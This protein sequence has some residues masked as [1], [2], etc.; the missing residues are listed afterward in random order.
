MGTLV[1]VVL[2]AAL[3]VWPR[4]GHPPHADAVVVLSGDHGERLPAALGLMKR[5][6]APTL[7][8]DGTPDFALW[9]RLCQEAQTFEVVC[10][11]PDPD[12]T[13]A[14]AKDAGR[15]AEG[16]RWKRVVVVTTT[17]HVTRA[18][19]LFRRCFDGGVAA[20]GAHP[21]Y[22]W[23]DSARQILHEWLGVIHAMT[24]A[25]SC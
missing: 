13:R 21:P 22:G 8:L 15:L 23:S 4:T 19:L 5:G 9:L 11:R 7:V 20:V 18:G 17:Y 6:V 14:E 24:L 25:R 10:L 16:R 12:G 1:P 3:F 2:T